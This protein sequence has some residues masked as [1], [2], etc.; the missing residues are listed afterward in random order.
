[1]PFQEYVAGGIMTANDNKLSTDDDDLL[2][3]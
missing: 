1:M 2:I 3:D